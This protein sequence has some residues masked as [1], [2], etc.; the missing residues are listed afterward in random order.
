[1]ELKNFFVQDDA[2]NILSAATC[3]LYE[4]GTESLVEVLQGANGLALANPFVS[5]Q[6]GLVQFAAPN[7]LYDLRVVKGARDYRLRMQCNDV[8]ETTEVAER[9]ARA[10]EEKLKDRKSVGM[11]GWTR[12]F[13][14]K[15]IETAEDML[16][17]QAINPREF[18]HLVVDKPDPAD[19]STWDWKP[20]LLAAAA[21]GPV[22]DGNGATFRIYN[23]VI[24]ERV[25]L[26]NIKIKPASSVTG[27]VLL[28][29]GGDD[30]HV[31]VY[32]DADGKGIGCIE[33]KGNRVTGSVY[34]S[35]IIGQPQAAGGTQG[36][37]KVS[38]TDCNMF[39][40]G[41][42]LLLGTSTNTSI[43]RLVTTDNTVLAAT[44]NTVR[45]V[46]KNVQCGWVTT[47]DEVHCESL[48]ID[49]VRDNGIYH[50]QGKATAATV[51]IRDCHDEPVVAKAGLQIDQL[52]TIDCHGFS[53]MSN[54]SFTVNDYKIISTDPSKQYQ[55]LAVRAD[56]GSSRISIGRLS[57]NIYLVKDPTLGGI[58]QLMAGTVPYMSIGEIDLDVHYLEGSTKI[59]ANIAAVEGLNIN[60]LA[61]RLIDETGTL[62]PADKFDFRI[63]VALSRSSAIGS[64]FNNSDSG[65]VRVANILQPLLQL[66][67]GAEVSVTYGPYILQEST[68][69]PTPPRVVSTGV[70]TTGTW[71]K[72]ATIDIKSSAIGVVT[73]YRCTTGGTPG[74]WRAVEWVTGRGMT[75]PVLTANDTGV[76]FMDTSLV[77]GTG[78]PIWWT[79]SAWIDALGATV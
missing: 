50:L 60:R 7:G 23:T 33:A 64:V 71:P 16:S 37:L 53:S 42:N 46:G 45:A 66:P 56:N 58:F 22:I 67:E 10:L 29:I 4:R 55:P 73:R 21:A 43:P 28:T 79:G 32:V 24:P 59:L 15:Q 3:Y 36:A 61:I 2:G 19:D 12:L 74:T 38:G 49:G 51:R 26:S 5:D 75:R 35:N 27:G 9:A 69:F 39:V 17:L 63:P 78:K 52:T 8:T 11:L 48:I 47:Q 31:E 68:E 41:E 40:H 62:T 1:M 44:R 76:D 57:G 30:S 54:A 65:E 20:A 77:A 34:A 25:L 70:P 13:N 18:S 72:G 6:Q 14:P